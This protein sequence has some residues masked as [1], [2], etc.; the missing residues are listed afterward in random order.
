MYRYIA[1]NDEELEQIQIKH[2]IGGR[3]NRQHAN[4]EDI[5]IMNKKN[6][7]E[8]YNTCGIGNFTFCLLVLSIPYAINMR[9]KSNSSNS[10]INMLI[11]HTFISLLFFFII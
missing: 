5:L 10:N 11:Q 4:R 9:K 8:E 2:S 1:R 6:D 3:K 7:T